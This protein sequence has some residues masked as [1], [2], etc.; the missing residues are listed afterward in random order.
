MEIQ[1][2]YLITFNPQAAAAEELEQQEA[3]QTH[4]HQQQETEALELQ[5]LILGYLQ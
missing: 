4:L 5:H 1:A 3:L 2:D